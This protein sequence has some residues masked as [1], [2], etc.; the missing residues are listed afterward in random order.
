MYPGLYLQQPMYDGRG[1][2]ASDEQ[3]DSIKMQQ[4]LSGTYKNIQTLSDGTVLAKDAKGNLIKASSMSELFEMAQEAQEAAKEKAKAEEA[5]EEEVVSSKKKETAAAEEA[6]EEVVAPDGADGNEKV[7][8][9][10]GNGNGNGSG[11]VGK[12]SFKNYPL[13]PGYAWT[14]F[15]ALPKD[16]Q[17]KIKKGTSLKDLC[18]ALG[19][20]PEKPKNIEYLKAVNPNGIKDD[21]VEDTNKLDVIYK[22]QEAKKDDNKE[23]TNH[24]YSC[25]KSDDIKYN[26]TTKSGYVIKDG[27]KKLGYLCADTGFSFDQVLIIAS[28]GKYDGKSF[29]FRCSDNDKLNTDE[30]CWD[31]KLK[32]YKS[33]NGY[34]VVKLECVEDKNIKFDTKTDSD[35]VIT[36]KVGDKYI[37]LE[38]FMALQ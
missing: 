36:V 15:S 13:Q 11:S 17:E 7:G 26:G 28:K 10:K 3:T 37:S 27:N 19:L 1:G 30:F 16:V 22:S 20:N 5:E 8:N 4:V 14:K 21:K 34:K 24:N 23:K 12:I 33:K 29:K 18:N 32:T 9:G 2:A 31:K 6:A 25:N 38:E 35:G